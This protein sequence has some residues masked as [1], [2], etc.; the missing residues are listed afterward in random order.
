MLLLI[1]AVV[2]PALILSVPSRLTACGP[3]WHAAVCTA[4][5]L[6]S[7]RACIAPEEEGGPLA[8][9]FWEEFC[10][11]ASEEAEP[12][13][14]EV[15]EVTFRSGKLCVL[16]SGAGVDEL[17]QLNSAL[18]SFLDTVDGARCAGSATLL[19]PP[20]SPATLLPPLTGPAA[21]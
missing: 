16:A 3:R 17:Q 8:G 21:P 9:P 6:P 19:P 14:L 18:G 5:R 7:L 4:P 12:L 10:Q 2:L 13:G 15:Q 20:T 11:A 1:S